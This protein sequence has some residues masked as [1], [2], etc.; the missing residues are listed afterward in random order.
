MPD[1]RS[2]I[3]QAY[4]IATPLPT[5][6]EALKR[7]IAQYRA[8]W[9]HFL[10]NGIGHSGIDLGC[11]GG[12]FLCFLRESG[13]ADLKGIDISPQQVALAQQ[14]GLENVF[15]GD[16]LTALPSEPQQYDV[17]AALNLLEHL[18]RDELFTL[19]DAVK[20]H[21][22]PGGVLLVVV[23]NARGVFGAKVRWADITH[24]LSFTPEA[25][26]QVFTVVGLEVIA[27]GEQGP[28]VHGPVSL[29]RWL[30]WQ[31]VRA[32]ALLAVMAETGNYW[33]RCFTQDMLVVGR[34]SSK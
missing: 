1:F 26:R 8:R 20:A 17:I 6:P 29:L 7:Q 24:E 13:F 5:S 34:C 3:Y 14:R 19:L 18:T 25:I 21:L 31:V 10:P 9:Q 16:V 15:V 22:K 11:G 30:I 28:I 27:I 23:P 12:E 4:R 32:G 33:D 2:R